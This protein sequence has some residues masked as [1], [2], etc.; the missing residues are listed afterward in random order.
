M[1]SR[2]ENKDTKGN[3]S[4][5]EVRG[6]K[7]KYD[8]LIHDNQSQKIQIIEIIFSYVLFLK[9]WNNNL[10]GVSRI[11]TYEVSYISCRMPSKSY[12]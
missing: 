2:K 1:R 9:D 10:S 4:A 3:I 5:A 12:L 6:I 8:T 7:M 11:N